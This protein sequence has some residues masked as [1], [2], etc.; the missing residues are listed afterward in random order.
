MMMYPIDI[1]N[2]EQIP[3][4]LMSSKERSRFITK[5]YLCIDFQ[6][7][8]TFGL[9]LYTKLNNLLTF[10]NSDIGR[11]LLGLSIGGVI[12]TF[13]TLMCCIN[14]FRRPV[15]KYMLLIIF[16]LS[17]SYIISNMLLYYDSKTIIIATGITLIDL[18]LMTLISLFIKVNDYFIEFLFISSISLILTGII[19]VFIMSTFLQLLIT[20]TGSI[21]FSG[22]VIYDTKMITSNK[23]RTYSKNDF[24][25]ASINLYIDIINLFLYILQCLT[26]TNSQN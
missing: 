20:G 11:G 2:D 7:I 12:M 25:L 26:L 10:Y 4:S 15:S 13:G 1:P 9:C 19:N 8:T 3:E 23:C 24:V 18:V 16:S 17:M 21:V 5:V 14:L 6:L 22:F